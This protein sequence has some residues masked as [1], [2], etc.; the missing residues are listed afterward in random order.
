MLKAL[1]LRPSIVLALL[2]VKLPFP[3]WG[4]TVPEIL[5]DV[6][7]KR[8]WPSRPPPLVESRAKLM[9]IE[10]AVMLILPPMV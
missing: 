4:A 2:R 1:L 10:L 9:S 7:D 6:V 5:P 3:E 8:M